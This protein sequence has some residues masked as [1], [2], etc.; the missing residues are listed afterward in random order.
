MVKKSKGRPKKP[1]KLKF[2]ER[3]IIETLLHEGFSN[4][5]IAKKLKRDKSTVTREI[6]QNKG[7]PGR[8]SYRAEFAQMQSDFR[9]YLATKMNPSKNPQ[10]WAYVEEKIKEGWS[11]EIIS[12]TIK[13]DM[14]GFSVS[15]ETIYKYVFNTRDLSVYLPCRRYYR[16]PKG[17]RKAKKSKIPNRLSILE[18]PEIINQRKEVGHWES[19]SIVSRKS[20]VG[21]NVMVERQT[22]YVQITKIP[23]LTSAITQQTITSRLS[24]LNAQFRK[25]ITYDN[26]SENSNHELINQELGTQSYFC[27]PYHS[28][29]KGSVEQINMLIRR[30][31]PKGSDLAKL[32]DEQIE[33]IET[34]LNTRPRKCL[35]YQTPLEVLNS[36]S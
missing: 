8:S 36:F 23:N 9:K 20:K 6:N 19:D 30:Y 28:W 31:V 27:E 21:L 14:P 17:P 24:A 12:G 34:K 25:S 5:A 22:R 33:Y 2:K 15:H 18:R 3:V 13:K 32:T 7:G 11:P 1:K 4:G 29:E 35:E 26:G 16:R 10:I